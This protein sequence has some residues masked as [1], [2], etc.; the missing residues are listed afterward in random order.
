MNAPLILLAS[1]SPRRR[2][3]LT[4]A[5]IGHVASAPAFDDSLLQPGAIAS[6]GHWVTSLA[7]LKAWSQSLAHPDAE[8]VLG[9]D[10]A[11]VMD[12]RLIGTPQSASEAR[13]MIRDFMDRD[14]AVVT[15]VAIIDRRT[16]RNE[17]HLFSDGA[18]VSM[19]SLSA[20]QIEAYLET[21]L[22][23][24]KAGAYNLLERIDA[25]WPLTYSGDPTTIMGLPMNR[26]VGRLSSILRVP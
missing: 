8:M 7:Y 12:D 22:W 13:V 14:H 11:C 1:R 2:E 3:L 24:G 23:Q 26:L 20:S 5:G 18:S 16:G 10:T 25:G 15:G 4:Q 6:P 19:G 21:G 17:R 9:S